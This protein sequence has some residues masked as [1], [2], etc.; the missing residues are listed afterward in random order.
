MADIKR[1]DKIRVKDR[2][3]WP[4]PPGYKLANSEGDVTQ[5][6]EKEGFVVMHLRK[7]NSDIDLGSTL[8]FRLDQVEKI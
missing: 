1:G 7:T 3:D 2:K 4:S 5:V 8:M 6:M